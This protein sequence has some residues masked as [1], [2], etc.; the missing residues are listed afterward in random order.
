MVSN[1]PVKRTTRTASVYFPSSTTNLFIFLSKKQ[2]FYLVFDGSNCR[3]MR[4]VD[5]NIKTNREARGYIN[6]GVC[7]CAFYACVMMTERERP[8]GGFR[9]LGEREKR[10]VRGPH[11]SPPTYLSFILVSF[12]YILE[13][14]LRLSRNTSMHYRHHPPLSPNSFYPFITPNN[15][16]ISFATN[17]FFFWGS[18]KL[19]CRGESAA[20]GR[21]I[22]WTNRLFSKS[23]KG[24]ISNFIHEVQKMILVISVQF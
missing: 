23:M 5:L 14:P 19:S 4:N 9:S 1:S 20:L 8:P 17:N 2:F 3:R 22:P 13:S 24:K 7:P 10:A 15:D 18:I 16:I 6:E 21:R 11:R 12:I